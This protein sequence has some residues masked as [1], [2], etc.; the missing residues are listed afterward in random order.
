MNSSQGYVQAPASSV[1]VRNE[2]SYKNP[3]TQAPPTGYVNNRTP[4]ILSVPAIKLDYNIESMEAK[5]MI[6]PRS[7]ANTSQPK[8]HN[9]SQEP[10]HPGPLVNTHG[11]YAFYPPLTSAQKDENTPPPAHLNAVATSVLPEFVP[12]A[13]PVNDLQTEPLDLA[14]NHTQSPKSDAPET[15]VPLQL[16]YSGNNHI[17]RDPQYTTSKYDINTNAKTKK[18][19][20]LEISLSDHNIKASPNAL[21]S[22]LTTKSTILSTALS[23]NNSVVIPFTI[24][25]TVPCINIKTTSTTSATTISTSIPSIAPVV[26]PTATTTSISSYIPLTNNT[27]SPAIIKKNISSTITTDIPSITSTSIPTTTSKTK[28]STAVSTVVSTKPSSTIS[29]TNLTTRDSSP[30]TPPPVLMPAIYTDTTSKP[31]HHKLK[32]AWLQRH[33]WAE[34]LKEAG[35]SIDQS[36]SSSFS[37]IDDTPPVLECEIVKKRK[38]TKSTSGINVNVEEA[39][40]D[41]S[42]YESDV[43]QQSLTN[44]TKK[45]RKRKTSNSKVLSENTTESDK[46]SDFVVENKVLPVKTPKK[47]GRKPKVVVS[48]PLKKGKPGETEEEVRF[49]QS[50]PCLNVGP[51][52]HKC[53][54]CR[55]FLNRR[56]KDL[57]SEDEVD[58]IFCRFYAFRRLFTSKAGQLVNAG[59]PDPFKDVS[60]VSSKIYI[61]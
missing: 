23:S 24:T 50:G 49:L 38:K 57:T 1:I 53:R 18:L 44:G 61:F 5:S 45:L 47:R 28:S 27:V 59:F 43:E 39:S 58:N 7:S 8:A 33:A 19:N 14:V 55:I 12:V 2:A 26:Y 29:M 31:H 46:D 3:P 54:E 20:I 11:R 30:S 4:T 56:R 52:I 37:Q 42:S 17:I 15:E 40:A 13:V 21:I 41:I 25:A 6:Y 10:L 32:K 9:T 34:D 51:K 36:P 16:L 35:V 22:T 48:I 60:G